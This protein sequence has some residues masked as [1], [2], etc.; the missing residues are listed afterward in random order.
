MS[1][2]EFATKLQSTSFSTTIQSH[3]W[4]VPTLQSI[5]IVMIGVVFVSIL[6]VALRVLGKSRADEPL[7]SVWS[8]FAPFLWA[9]VIVMAVTGILL[10]VSEPVRELMTFSFRLKM[11][12]L[13]IGVASAVLFGRSVRGAAM[14]GAASGARPSAGMRAGAVLTIVLWLAIIFL[15]RAI[16]YDDVIWGEWSPA[17]LQGGGTA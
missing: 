17:V 8:R 10:T 2:L 15:G 5:H 3:A 14:A 6:M 1:L 4:I 9:G 12:L 13:A 16:A 11:L 7:A